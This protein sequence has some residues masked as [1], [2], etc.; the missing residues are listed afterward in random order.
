MVR[1]RPPPFF[2]IGVDNICVFTS[3]DSGQHFFDV[4]AENRIRVRKG[5][6]YATDGMA[7]CGSPMTSVPERGQVCY[8]FLATP[9][10]S[11]HS[12]VLTVDTD[13]FR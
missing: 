13:S 1:N 10:F 11:E 8:S 4:G 12:C 3:F 7:N 6:S 9:I 5:F 2:S